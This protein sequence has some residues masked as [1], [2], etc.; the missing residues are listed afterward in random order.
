MR[1]SASIPRQPSCLLIILTLILVKTLGIVHRKPSRQ[2]CT[3]ICANLPLLILPFW[4]GLVS[5]PW[6][7]NAFQVTFASLPFLLNWLGEAVVTLVEGNVL[8]NFLHFYPLCFSVKIRS[9]QYSPGSA[10]YLSVGSCSVC[11]YPA[12]RRSF[13]QKRWYRNSS[14]FTTMLPHKPSHACWGISQSN[15]D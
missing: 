13:P 8:Q 5:K 9:F 15:Y 12:T 1:L 10:F 11:R 7:W 6:S 3:N 2:T 14:C 4:L